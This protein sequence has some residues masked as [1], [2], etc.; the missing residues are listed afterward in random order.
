MTLHKTENAWK[1][2]VKGGGDTNGDS[3]DNVMK[4]LA[5][6][7]RGILNKL[8]PQRFDTLVEQFG[9]L[10][11]DTEDKLK[12]CMELVFEKVKNPTDERLFFLL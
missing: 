12:L 8:T 9:N 11:I 3:E 2:G 4:D 1:P 10:E 7:A 6:K 5:K